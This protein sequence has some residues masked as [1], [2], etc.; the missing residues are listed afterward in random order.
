MRDELESQKAKVDSLLEVSKICE[1]EATAFKDVVEKKGA[2]LDAAGARM[3]VLNNRP[4]EV[5]SSISRCRK[6]LLEVQKNLAS[7][8]EMV[9][10]SVALL[11]RWRRSGML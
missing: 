7:P 6:E 10:A 5:S 1:K 8:L 11:L 9:N 3:T 2:C 4:D